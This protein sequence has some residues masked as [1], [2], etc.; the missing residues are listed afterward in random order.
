MNK[1]QET[2]QTQLNLTWYYVCITVC[3]F[4]IYLSTFVTNGISLT[5]IIP[6]SHRI[7]RESFIHYLVELQ[8]FYK[9]GIQTGWKS[10]KIHSGLICLI[11]G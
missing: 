11:S 6:M 4:K 5:T 1:I 7:Q 9:R 3:H 8:H 10:L 2:S